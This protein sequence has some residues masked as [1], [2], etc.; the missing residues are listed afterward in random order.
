MGFPTFRDMLDPLLRVLAEAP[1][2]MQA[3]VAQD[4]VADLLGLGENE[5]QLLVPGG[6]QRLYRHRTN[7]A[8][9]R[10]KRASLS[11]S[12][13]RG[14]WMITELGLELVRLR[15]NGLSREEIHR[16]GNVGRNQRMAACSGATARSLD[17]R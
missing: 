13:T 17:D 6:T 8:H 15:P 11:S 5:R 1:E 4:R 2:G 12:P 14:V 7:W 10:L 16:I 3:R 9:D